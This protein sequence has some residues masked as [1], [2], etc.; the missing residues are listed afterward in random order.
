M[1][2]EESLLKAINANGGALISSCGEGVCGTCEV[3]VLAGQPMHLD[4]VMSDTDK[5]EIRVM[6]PCV[7]K[8]VSEKLVLDI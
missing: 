6:Y 4:S 3:R 5:D 8:S 7:S 1:Q 2:P